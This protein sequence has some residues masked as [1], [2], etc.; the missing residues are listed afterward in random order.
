MPLVADP[1]DQRRI[2]QF[3][4]FLRM[5]ICMYVA[6]WKQAS[7]CDRH[8][9]GSRLLINQGREAGHP[10][11]VRQM[12]VSSAGL[13]VSDVFGNPVGFMRPD[14]QMEEGSWRGG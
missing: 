2:P 1:G 6:D 5:E 12:C 11:G 8:N 13:C 4:G 14:K 9:P 3:G 7:R 10:G